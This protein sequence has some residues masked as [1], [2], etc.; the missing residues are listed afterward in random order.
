[1]AKVVKPGNKNKQGNAVCPQCG[2]RVLMEKIWGD[3]SKCPHCSIAYR[4][5]IPAGKFYR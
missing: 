1:M 2:E 4:H 3:P 5:I